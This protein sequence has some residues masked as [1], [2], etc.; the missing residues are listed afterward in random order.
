MS[1]QGMPCADGANLSCDAKP[2]LRRR[3][4]ACLDALD[5]GAPG[6]GRREPGDLSVG[7]AAGI[8]VAPRNV[9]ESL[10]VGRE[11][12]AGLSLICRD[13]LFGIPDLPF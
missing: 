9:G 1:G 6:R 5:S 7:R 2:V 4:S 11:R 10:I 8:P 13:D 12:A 3:E